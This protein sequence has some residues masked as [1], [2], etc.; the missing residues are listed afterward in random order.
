MII[1]V[2]GAGVV[3][4]VVSSIAAMLVMLLISPPWGTGTILLAVGI[5]AYASGSVVAVVA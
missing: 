1:G 2:Q 4:A 5:A 3:S